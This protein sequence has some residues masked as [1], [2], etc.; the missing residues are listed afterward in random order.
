MGQCLQ[1]KYI[2]IIDQK[3]DYPHIFNPVSF[4][5]SVLPWDPL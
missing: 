1:L 3:I 5:S 2:I 4:A